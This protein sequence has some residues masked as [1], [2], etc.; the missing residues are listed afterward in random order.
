MAIFSPRQTENHHERPLHQTQ[1]KRPAKFK[2]N[3]AG[4]AVFL[5]DQRSITKE[6]ELELTHHFAPRPCAE[7]LPDYQ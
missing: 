3:L 1:C 7:C 5:G 4:L 6:R 2:K